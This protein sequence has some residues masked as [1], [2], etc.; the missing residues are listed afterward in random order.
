MRWL[1]LL[2]SLIA[3]CSSCDGA[4]PAV[5]FGLDASGRARS[6]PDEVTAAPA[7]ERPGEA[8]QLPDGTE[9]VDVDGA[10]LA[11]GGAVRATYA[12]DVDGDG[13][14]D[15]LALVDGPPRALFLRREGAGFEAPVELA[16]VPAPEGCRVGDA[17]LA[18][19]G[20]AWVE[21]RIVLRCEAS[22]AAERTD[23][24]VLDTDRAPRLLERLAVLSAEGRAE[25]EV[26][27]TLDRDDRDEDEHDDLVV[28]V[29]VG[30]ADAPADLTLGWLDRPSGLARQANEPEATLVERSRDALRRLRAVPREALDRSLRVL[31]LHRALC[32]EPGL[33]RLVVGNVTGLACGDSDGAGRAATT[34]VRAHA[35]L[36]ETAAALDASASLDAPGLRVDDERRQ[37]VRDALA[38][39]PAI[40]ASTLRVGPAVDVPP[41]TGARLSALAFL[42]EDRVLVRGAAPVVWDL[43]SGETSP[44]ESGDRRVLDPSGHFR[45]AAV[46]RSCEGQVLVLEQNGLPA[47][48]PLLAACEPPPGAACPLDGRAREDDGGWTVLGWAPQGI[49][50]LRDAELRLVPLDLAARPAGPPRPLDPGTAPPVP[51]PPGAISADGHHVAS[52]HGSG[53]RVQ[54]VWPRGEPELL[55]PPGWGALAGEPTDVAVSGSGRRVAVLRAGRVY[56]IERGSA[57]AP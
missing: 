21:G 24:L 16:R 31:A 40:A 56:L 36:G 23:H 57:P 33:A 11:P 53:V 44:A 20:A 22:P 51:L 42:A 8:R 52:L 28:G 12:L 13:D 54:A 34:V 32:R 1:A 14:R 3:G 29:R 18:P 4:G 55:W 15:A 39:A 17:R 49:L 41:A 45:V 47:G 46:E 19:L 30:A 2:G 5:P 26:S 9:R 50:T 35:A 37:F 38:A 48:S 25:G 27:L 10:P 7:A 43:A 6:A